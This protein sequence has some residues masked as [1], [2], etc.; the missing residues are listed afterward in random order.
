MVKFRKAI[1]KFNEKVAVIGTKWFGSMPM[2]WL[3]FVWGLLGMVPWLPKSFQNTVLLVSSAWIQ[4]WALPLLAVGTAV[5]SKSS[6]RRAKEDHDILR[7]QFEEVKEM[8]KVNHDL[9][10][11]VKQDV[12][13][14]EQL[15][16]KLNR[17]VALIDK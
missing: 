16:E 8:Q 1:T 4:L 13:L 10:L 9:I 5:L 2:F 14:N 15:L 7:K 17:L 12:A 11:F 3:F 6:E